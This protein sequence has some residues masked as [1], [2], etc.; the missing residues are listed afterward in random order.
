MKNHIALTLFFVA[1]SFKVMAQGPPP[2][3]PDPGDVPIDGGISFLVASG[4]A[5]GAYQY[6]KRKQDKEDSL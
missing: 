5:Y 6:K 3:P 1:L 4:I 2:P